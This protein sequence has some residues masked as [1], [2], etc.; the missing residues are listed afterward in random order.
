MAPRTKVT[1]WKTQMICSGCLNGVKKR[2]LSG[3]T[4]PNSVHQ[5]DKME[6]TDDLQWMS[7]WSEEEELV[8]D[9]SSQLRAPWESR[10]GLALGGV[11]LLAIAALWA[12]MKGNNQ[13]V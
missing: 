2:N 6:N 3:I 7:Q 9:Y 12:S 5:G 10:H 11:V 8:G 13:A 4:H 1:K